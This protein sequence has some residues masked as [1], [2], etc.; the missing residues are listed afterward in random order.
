LVSVRVAITD[1][2]LFNRLFAG[3]QDSQAGW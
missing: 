1:L 2:L 3:R